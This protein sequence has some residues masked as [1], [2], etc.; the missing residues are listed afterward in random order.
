MDPLCGWCY[1][2][3]NN[4]TEIYNQY[5]DK[6]DFELVVGGMWLYHN[7]PSGSLGLKQFVA[8]H[9]PRMIELTGAKVNQKYFDLAGDSSYTFSSLEPCAA[10]VLVK[11]LNPEKTFLFAKEIQKMMFTE[12]KK[13]NELDN[14]LPILKEL[15]IDASEFNN[16]WL[17][18]DNI[19]NAKKEFARAS[20]LANGFPTLTYQ[21]NNQTTMLASGYFKKER[22]ATQIEEL[23][24]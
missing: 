7:A 5:K 18:E 9:T 19:S 13:L 2:N 21:Q 14:Y 16:N 6:I 23:L 3:G 24:V 1:G 10:I 15:G 4:I 11:Q 20:A 17:S 8:S 22:I 12:G